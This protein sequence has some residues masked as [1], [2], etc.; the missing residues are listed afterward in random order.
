M[1]TD[2]FIEFE[3]DNETYTLDT[4]M[5]FTRVQIADSWVKFDNI[6]FNVTAPNSIELELVY[7]NPSISTATSGDK[8][9]EYYATTTGG[10]V[11]FNITEKYARSHVFTPILLAI[12]KKLII[13]KTHRLVFLKSNLYDEGSFE[14]L[15]FFSAGGAGGSFPLKKKTM[16]PYVNVR[17]AGV[18]KTQ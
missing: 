6:S 12:L 8:V 16:I 2:V 11:Y 4:A 13:D 18:K 15:I 14:S 5:S 17:L 10:T 7:L 9:L 1:T 3:V